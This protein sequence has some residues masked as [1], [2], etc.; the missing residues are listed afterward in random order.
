MLYSAN[1]DNLRFE[2][3]N[4]KDKI[5]FVPTVLTQIIIQLSIK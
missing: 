2:D 4:I 5:L 3:D 1:E